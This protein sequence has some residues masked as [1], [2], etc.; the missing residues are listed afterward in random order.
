M[1]AY[2]HN[3]RN[4]ESHYPVQKMIFII[5]GFIKYHCCKQVRRLWAFPRLPPALACKSYTV[6]TVN[7]ETLSAPLT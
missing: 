4:K 1:Y 7:L 3:I 2:A 5:A 6:S